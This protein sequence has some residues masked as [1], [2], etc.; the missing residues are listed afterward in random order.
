MMGYPKNIIDKANARYFRNMQALE[1][2]NTPI[3]VSLRLDKMPAGE[4]EHQYVFYVE[5]ADS[6]GL[7]IAESVGFLPIRAPQPKE[8]KPVAK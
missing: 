3:N 7:R 6:S 2:D 4:G 8:D 1:S 5:S